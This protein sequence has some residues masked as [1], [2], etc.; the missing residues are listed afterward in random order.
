MQF[1]SKRQRR[2][3]TLATPPLAAFIGS[4][5][6]TAT[7]ACWERG[8]I[9]IYETYWRQRPWRL[10]AAMPW[11]QTC[12]KATAE[13][14]ARCRQWR[15]SA[16]PPVTCSTRRCHAHGPAC[17]SPHARARSRRFAGTHALCRRLRSM[18]HGGW[19]EGA[20]KNSKLLTQQ[21][22]FAHASDVTTWTNSGPATTP[23]CK[24]AA[25]TLNVARTAKRH[26]VRST[27]WPS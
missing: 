26:A 8:E 3:R 15:F 11:R 21:S 25:S 4:V 1:L 5:A 17:W 2:I 19:N 9:T 12:C 14:P 10:C 6:S 20:L 13:P 27:P 7:P 24:R 16:S 22:P 23:P 18:R